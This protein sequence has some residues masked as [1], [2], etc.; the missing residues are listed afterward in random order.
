M[1]DLLKKNAIQFI[2]LLGVADLFADLTYEGGRS[3]TGPYL[4]FL[5]ASAT[6]V[7]LVAGLG[8]LIGY[9]FRFVSGYFGE[10]TGRYWFVTLV[11]YLINMSAVP[12]LALAGEGP[13]CCADNRQGRAGQR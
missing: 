13:T 6:A 11:G 5:G 2:I 3:I 1:K 8:E 10:K 7:G 9:G 12:L 4:A